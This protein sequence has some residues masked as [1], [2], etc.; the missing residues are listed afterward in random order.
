VD[1]S[2]CKQVAMGCA[3]SSMAKTPLRGADGAATSNE[4]DEQA[5]NSLSITNKLHDGIALKFKRHNVFTAGVDVDEK[6]PNIKN[7][8]KTVAQRNLIRKLI[9]CPQIID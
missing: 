9:F 8:P 6:V 2:G 4:E 3:D 5:Q 7:I 1:L